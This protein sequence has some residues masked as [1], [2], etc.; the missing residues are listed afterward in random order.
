M[1]AFDIPWLQIKNNR[2]YTNQIIR[3]S[4]S[5][6]A[7]I[8]GFIFNEIIIPVIK[9]HFYVTE[10]HKE[11]NKIFYFRKPLWILV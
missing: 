11:A 4:N 6:L 2:L 7:E 8:V 9:Y 5:V 3:R 1:N 10:R